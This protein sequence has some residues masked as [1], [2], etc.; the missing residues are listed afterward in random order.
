MAQQIHIVDTDTCLG[1]GI[2]AEIC[3][4]D[5]LEMLDEKAATV[6]DR[7]DA[8]ILCGQCVAVCPTESLSMPQL[9]VEDFER[10]PD[11]P[12]EYE[13]LFDFLRR[14]RS[15]RVFKDRPVEREVIQKV[16]D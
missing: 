5:I 2:C 7:A 14:R 10:L 8:C 4:E 9:P 13:Q 1:D 11:Q 6:A 3:L 15:V 16:L 12:F